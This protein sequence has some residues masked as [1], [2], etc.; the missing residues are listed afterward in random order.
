MA[1]ITISQ[2]LEL[3]VQH[4]EAGRLAEAGTIYRQ[5]LA[6]QPDH[7]EA[8]HLL[9]VIAHHEGREE[10]AVELIGR[11]IRLGWKT[12]AAFSN[13]GEA[14]RGMGRLEE[15]ITAYRDALQLHP[16]HAAAHYNLGLALHS[17]GQWGDAITAFRRA[18][19]LGAVHADAQSNLGAS[20]AKQ[21]QLAEAV[22]A[23]RGALRLRP[24]AAESYFN[25]GVVLTQRGEIEDAIAAYRSA[26]RLGPEFAE[27]QQNLGAA[28]IDQG[29][30]EAAIVALHRA[31]EL[32]PEYVEA[33][34]NLGNALRDQERLDDAV[35]AFRRAIELQPDYLGAQNNLGNIYKE[36]GRLEEAVA[37]F[38]RASECPGADA[39]VQS[40]L[41]MALN[42]LPGIDAQVI[43]EEQARWNRRF[44][45]TVG[46]FIL[47]HANDRDL[48]RRLRVGYVSPDL[49]DHTLGRNL[50]PLFR[51]HDRENFAIFCYANVAHPDN[52][53]AEFRGLVDQWRDTVG[54]SDEAL[55][56]MIRRDGI[57]V[58]VDLALHTAGNR[59]PV[60]AREPAPVQV[61]FAGY[62]GSTGLE[63]IRCR[64]SDFNLE[65]GSMADEDERRKGVFLIRT[66]WCYDPCGLDLATNDLPA[67]ERGFVT[68]GS[69][70]HFAKVND[71]VL[72]V[73]GRVLRAVAGSKLIL[74]CPEGS[75]RRGVVERLGTEGVAVER[76]EFIERRSRKEY[77]E[78]YQ[79]MDVMLDSFPY[80]GHT[81]SLDAL[82]M[83]VPV[84]T[85]A[86]RQIVS[87]AGLSQ[88][89]N[90]E[91]R[92]LV[93]F[94]EDEYVRIATEL[95]GDLPRLGRLRATLRTRM[96][97][98]LLMDG[99]LFARGIELSFRAMWR[100]WCRQASDAG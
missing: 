3:A 78:M 20:L 43:A 18:I 79:R 12:G 11:S 77:L 55:V 16:D 46:G 29:Q 74:L 96:E 70:N 91:L 71:A 36:L 44:G 76:V 19:E 50:R 1:T 72:R 27:A 60:F 92:E 14:Y 69:L 48:K 63:K 75:S 47:P 8:H 45:D 10:A 86:G 54:M 5:I 13:L 28:L 24:D 67:G 40:N 49:R 58:L 99:K 38:R 83:G 6:V 59:L 30:S 21:G 41:I 32:K 64:I 57:D 53:T 94:S 26:I 31:L 25:L 4:H 82:W 84:V 87:R 39:A 7:A 62:P 56:E 95:A 80:G 42:Y 34:Y 15:A 89:S 23:Y 17:Q 68:F 66:F 88:L 22:A 9:G 97:K 90:L 2:A 37:A 52:I 35:E 81:T 65:E 100:E 33:Q 61:S 85:L 51:A 98:S 73:W 93:A